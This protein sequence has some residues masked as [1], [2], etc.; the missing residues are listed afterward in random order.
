MLLGPKITSHPWAQSRGCGL[1]YS[2][3][4]IISSVVQKLKSV[5]YQEIKVKEVA[6]KK[7]ILQSENEKFSIAGTLRGMTDTVINTKQIKYF[8]SEKNKDCRLQKKK[9]QVGPKFD[10]L[11]SFFKVTGLT[12]TRCQ[13]FVRKCQNP[14]NHCTK[15]K[16]RCQILR[17]TS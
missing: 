12:N 6:W 5:K 16:Y 9:K 8:T 17:V 11:I 1:L 3:S 14:R 10:L 7:I 15:E 2:E 13:L 4:N